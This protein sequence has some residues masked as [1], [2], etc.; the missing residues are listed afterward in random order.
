M[1][2]EISPGKIRANVFEIKKFAV[3]D[4]PGIRTTFFL[5]GCPLKCRWCH[6]PESISPQSQLAYYEHK[7]IH[8]GECVTICP[9][10]AHEVVNGKHI[11]NWDKCVTCGLCEQACLGNSLK[12]FGYTISIDEALAL[13]LEDKDFYESNGGVT[14]SGGEPLL[15][16]DFCAEFFKELHKLGINCAVDTC[17]CVQWTA[18]EKVLPFT[19]IFLVDLKHAD[20][21]E[22]R[23]LT[24]QG[25][26]LII[27]NIQRLSNCG[28][29]IEIRIPL[30]PGANDSE[31]NLLATAEL[32]KAIN[33]ERVKLLPYHTMAHSKYAALGMSENMPQVKVSEKA[34]LDNAIYFLSTCGINAM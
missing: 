4:G 20:D 6:N 8:C 26:E 9:N 10:N 17:A 21:T 34:N 22:H 15:Q 32:L 13:A 7:C 5:K 16:A 2:I 27:D 29:K 11:F 23:K 12:F 33:I 19:N 18:I 31:T 3:H 25:N 14:V 24:G 1:H 28:A 30:I